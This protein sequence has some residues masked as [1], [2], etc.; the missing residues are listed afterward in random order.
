MR[1]IVLF[2]CLLISQVSIANQDAVLGFWASDSSVMEIIREG[3]TLKGVV[4]ALR[5]PTYLE[6]ENTGKT[7]AVRTDDNNPIESL[8]VRTILGISMFSEY[9][10][11]DGLWQGKIYDPE[12]GNTYQSRMKVNR[13]GDLEIRG[14]IGMPMFGRTAEFVPLDRCTEA[15]I[16]MLPQLALDSPCAVQQ[17]R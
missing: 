9:V 6:E 1:I 2:I 7:G 11:D 3:D 12:S 14:Y 10:Y 13:K 15:I 5:N 17:K 4:R 16:A 8:R